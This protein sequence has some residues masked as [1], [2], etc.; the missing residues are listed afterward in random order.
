ML[1]SFC[2]G[3]LGLIVGLAPQLST[4]EPVVPEFRFQGYNNTDFYGADLQPLFNS[5]LKDCQRLCE[6]DAKCAGFVFNQT[7]SA[8]FPKAEMETPS[9]YDG[10]FSAIKREVAQSV[11]DRAKERT[12]SLLFLTSSDLRAA[13]DQ[14]RDLGLQ[15]MWPTLAVEDIIQ[16]AR[17]LWRG[18]DPTGAAAT[19][20]QAVLVTDAADLWS[21]YARYLR[22]DETGSYTQRERR[23]QKGLTAAI[24]S[25]LRSSD[26]GGQA[27]ALLQVALAH[28][29]AWA[30]AKI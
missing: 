14:A 23:K 5:T 27:T 11:Q 9:V 26:A 7:S 29:K 6:G 10:A 15:V 2:A 8:C 16:K 17:R 24:N 1:R 12:E 22:H 13:H 3:L 21:E 20:A 25:Y 30:A 4:A 28:L 18:D 19:M